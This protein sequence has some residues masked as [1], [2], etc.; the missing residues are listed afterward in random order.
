MTCP[1]IA[2]LFSYGDGLRGFLVG[3]VVPDPIY[4]KDVAKQL[5][6]E[7]DLE[8]LCKNSKMIEHYLKALDDWG[9]K[10]HLNGLER[11]KKIYLDHESLVVRGLTT[12]TFKVVRS[13]A[14]VYYKD[15]IENLYK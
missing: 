7:G 15:I 5:G 10:N 6:V 12:S 2:E 3:I 9:K 11:L 14:K 13:K 1:G 4:I 8:K